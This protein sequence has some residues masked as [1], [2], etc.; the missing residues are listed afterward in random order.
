MRLLGRDGNAPGKTINVGGLTHNQLALRTS[1]VRMTSGLDVPIIFD[2]IHRRK[3]RLLI[4]K[5][6]KLQKFK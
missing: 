1:F 5:V 4:K 2:D 6:I 3:E